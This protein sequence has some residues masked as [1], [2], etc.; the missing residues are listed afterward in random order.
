M[1]DASLVVLERCGHVPYVEQP[2]ALFDAVLPFVAAQ[3]G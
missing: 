1:P 2:A 3:A